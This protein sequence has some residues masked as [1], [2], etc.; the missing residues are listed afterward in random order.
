MYSMADIGAKN[1]E[2]QQNIIKN[3]MP[4]AIAEDIQGTEAWYAWYRRRHIEEPRPFWP[5]IHIEFGS[6]EDY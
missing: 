3:I 6:Y 5:H 4:D 1:P 2:P